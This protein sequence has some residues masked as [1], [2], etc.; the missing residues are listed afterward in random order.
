MVRRSVNGAPGRGGSL[1]VEGVPV[2][3]PHGADRATRER[4]SAEV[5]AL[6]F[7]AVLVVALVLF[8]VFGH[9]QWFFLDDW[10][11]LA[12][13]SASSLNDLFR[14][15]NEHWSTLPILVYRALWHF[16]GLRTYVPYQLIAILLHLTA[17]VLLRVVMRR[18]G[19]HP[20]IATAAASLFALFGAGAQNIVWAFQMAWGASLVLGLTHLILA[21]HD[22]PI[23][24]RDV[25]GLL[26]G[27]A[28][29]LC[30]GVAVTMIF[31]VGLSALIRR[32]WRAA[33]FHTAPL[34]VLYLA[35]WFA[36]ARDRYSAAGG[37]IG[38]VVRFVWTGVGAAFGEMGHLPGAGL[39]LGILLVAGLVFAWHGLDWN[40]LRRRAAAPAAL[41]VGA[42]VFLAVAGLGR[43]SIFGPQFARS[44]RYLHVVAALS[45]PAVA[46][47]ADAFMR[48]WRAVGVVAFALLLV[49]IPG[50]IDLIVHYETECIHPRRQGPHPRASAGPVCRPGATPASTHAGA[51]RPGSRSDGYSSGVRAGRIPAPG[52]MD[53]IT[54]A[55]ASLAF[56]AVPIPT[57][58]GTRALHTPRP[59]RDPHLARRPSGPIRRPWSAPGLGTTKPTCDGRL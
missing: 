39:A 16:F 59:R 21:D 24:R 9:R 22:G 27:L 7:L 40:D 48:R 10:D 25:L 43:A 56:V 19:V 53:P 28:G 8:L 1:T 46:V 14:P 6:V 18:A 3:A 44:G 31:V 5:A 36:F 2:Q 51:L 26:A 49:G 54:S 47:A 17:A 15:H 35:W 37:S 58:D 38:V 33:L 32:G 57:R 52:H 13:R 12:S 50:N 23:D 42:V 20:W 29:M 11:F 34:A 30:S 4:R 55:Q 41:L 45:L